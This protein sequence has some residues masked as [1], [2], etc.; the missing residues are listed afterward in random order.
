M[1]MMFYFS[2]TI[3]TLVSLSPML[4]KLAPIW[5]NPHI[6]QK[7]MI[8]EYQQIRSVIRATWNHVD[9]ELPPKIEEL[10]NPETVVF[11]N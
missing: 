9:L 1:Q 6:R 5:N 3:L 8:L 11:A 2:F 10:L 4:C 7:K